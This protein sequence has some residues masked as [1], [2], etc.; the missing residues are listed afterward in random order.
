MKMFSI[1]SLFFAA[2]AAIWSQNRQAP[3]PKPP[4]PV[5]FQSKDGKITGWKI[6]IPGGRPLATPAIAEGK[7]FLG[8]GFGSHEFYAFDA[9]TGDPLWT[10]Q[11]ADDG[12]TAA[13]VD[14]GII[15]FN[16][17]S[18]ELETLT[19][20]GRRLWK[21]WLGDPLMSMP[22]L[23]DGQV[24][25]AYPNS[26]GD[27][28]YYVAAFDVKNGNELWKRP[29][30]GEIITAPVVDR[31]R[32]YVATVDGSMLA[33]NRRNGAQLWQE[34]RNAFHMQR[35]FAKGNHADT[36][37]QAAPQKQAYRN[38]AEIKHLFARLAIPIKQLRPCSSCYIVQI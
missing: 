14:N 9:N 6:T 13:V 36:L 33:L 2:V 37:I 38:E 7:I 31:D 32:L 18:C 4:K 1:A 29:L 26:R 23:A 21:K 16:T 10:Y 30:E 5:P 25:M 15:A 12:P 22:A 34:K 11:T 35:L 17:E 27:H 3:A 20:S 28:K 24:Y 19:T 8:G